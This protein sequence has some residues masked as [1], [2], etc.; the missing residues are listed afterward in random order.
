ME[1]GGRGDRMEYFEDFKIRA[2]EGAENGVE[3]IHGCNSE[4]MLM[5][6]VRRLA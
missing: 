4:E 3:H 6:A 2:A 1:F 5:Q